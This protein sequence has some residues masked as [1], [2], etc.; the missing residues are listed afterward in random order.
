M[1][2][3]EILDYMRW[4]VNE[5][6]PVCQRCGEASTDDAHHLLYG[7]YK[8]DRYLISVCRSCHEWF[9]KNKRKGIDSYE[10]LAIENYENYTKDKHVI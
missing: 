10:V 8:D 5:H 7:A 4:M 2:K 9:H 6:A 1:P 3:A